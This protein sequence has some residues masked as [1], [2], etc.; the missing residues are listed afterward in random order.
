MIDE[1]I[2]Y[3]ETGLFIDR[4]TQDVA[5]EDDGRDRKPSSSEGAFIH[6]SFLFGLFI[7]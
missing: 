1:S 6:G 4:P 7:A 5:A 3:P 2:E